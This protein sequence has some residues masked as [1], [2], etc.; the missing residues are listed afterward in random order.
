M[1]RHDVRYTKPGNSL[2]DFLMCELFH[3]LS[4]EI[5]V[6]YTTQTALS[7]IEFVKLKHSKTKNQEKITASFLGK[8]LDNRS[9]RM[10]RRLNVGDSI[11]ET[12]LVM[13]IDERMELNSVYSDWA[14]NTL[15]LYRGD[16]KYQELL[17]QKDK[18]LT[19]LRK[20]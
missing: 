15:I 17:D 3:E 11:Q 13:A 9:T 8:T 12:A 6:R 18:Y 10:W 5:E 20:I 14:L 2:G 7:Q 16:R 1:G 4:H 19:D